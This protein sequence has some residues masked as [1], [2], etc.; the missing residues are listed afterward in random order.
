MD[1]ERS[2]E[3]NVDFKGQPHY[4]IIFAV[5]SIKVIQI[6]INF[7]K[8]FEILT[9]KLFTKAFHWLTI[10]SEKW[11]V[12][13]LRTFIIN[14]LLALFIQTASAS[15][16]TSP[17]EVC[18]WKI[19]IV[20]IKTP[21][22]IASGIMLPDGF[23][24]TNRHVAEDHAL[25]M[26]RDFKGNIKRATPIP[27]SI[28][29]DLVILRPQGIKGNPETVLQ[30]FNETPAIL[31]V[32]AFDQGRNGPRVYS[33]S[34]FAHYPNTSDFPQARIHSDTKALPGN[35]GGA[36][37]DKN[38]R[39]IG[40]LASGD[41]KISEII[42]AVHVNDIALQTGG[43]HQSSFKATGQAIRICADTLFAAHSIIKNPPEPI[44]SKIMNHCLKAKN[45][46]LFDQAGQVFG[47]WWLFDKSKLFLK[48]S[49]ALDP[50]SPNTL[51]SLAVTYHLSRDWEKERV[52]LKR[53]LQIDPA[54]TQALR[55]GA[56]V[57]G[58]LKDREFAD[59][60]IALMKKHNPAA[61]PLAQSFIEKAL[62]GQKP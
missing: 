42:P 21:N 13:I 43:Q 16:C 7:F 9:L 35:S 57:A 59:Q 4:T 8:G 29:A 39:L 58:I 37:V 62:D 10:A 17:P 1:K 33:P 41:G 61:L 3:L 54:N 11:S 20:G 25:L 5:L 52:I 32:V 15:Q 19:K 55:L 60:V 53:Y 31:Y 30:F 2:S 22:M 38:G 24:L 50:K 18:A 23:V 28:P 48:E 36:V 56:Q 26:I 27:H 47:R 40:I 45:K 34:T 44:V 12:S 14:L 46:Q 6:E 51:M 49:E